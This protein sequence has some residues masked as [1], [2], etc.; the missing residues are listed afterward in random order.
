VLPS[1][2]RGPVKRQRV[3][4]AIVPNHRSRRVATKLGMT[5]VGQ[6][7]AADLLHDLWEVRL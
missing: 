5:I 1:K 6:V 7:I 2:A 4:A 3:E